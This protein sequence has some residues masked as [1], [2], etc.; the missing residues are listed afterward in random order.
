[1]AKWNETPR[2]VT[3]TIRIT[4]EQKEK[5]TKLAKKNDVRVSFLAYDIIK[6]Y[7]ETNN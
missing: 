2:N 6:Q 7:L 3:L 1:M 5:L 4:E